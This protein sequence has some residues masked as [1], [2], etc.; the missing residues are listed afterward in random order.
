MVE[1]QKL[2]Y[3][4]TGLLGSAALASAFDM[5]PLF[6]H[7]LA[8]PTLYLCIWK[9]T[10]ASLMPDAIFTVGVSYA[11]M[12]LVRIL[13]LTALMPDIHLHPTANSDPDEPRSSIFM[14]SHAPDQA[15]TPPAAKKPVPATTF[16]G[17]AK[18]AD[19]WLRGVIVKGVTENARKSMLLISASDKMY[20]VGM[21]AP[22]PVLTAS[23][24]C[25]I[26]LVN[27]SE[28][29]ATV[30]VNGEQAYLRIH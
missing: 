1:V 22:V 27:V 7:Y 17:P 9:V 30:E 11:L 28:T 23:G 8:V 26:K 13:L 12:F 15:G 29:W 25:H 19:D 24:A 6:G 10:R 16:T 18:S 21:S 2:N 20:E 3:S 14:N 4:F 5:I